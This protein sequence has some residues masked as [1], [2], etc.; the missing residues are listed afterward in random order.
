MT[1]TLTGDWRIDIDFVA[2]TASHT[3]HLEQEGETLSGRYRS[4]YG[5]HEIQGRVVGDEVEMRV[6]IHYQGC[7]T[8]YVFRGRIQGDRMDGEVNLG[9]YWSGSWKAQRAG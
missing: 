9:E 4:Q 7:G 2:G 1:R 8:Q 6:G 5:N 3:A